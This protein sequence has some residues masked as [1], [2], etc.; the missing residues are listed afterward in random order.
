MSYEIGKRYLI[1]TDNWFRAPDGECYNAAFGTLRGIYSSEEA[2]GVRTNAKSTNWYVQ[3]GNLTI[4]GCQIH[5][6][7]Q[8]DGVS[9]APP[10][11]EF[12]HADKHITARAGMTRIYDADPR[13]DGPTVLELLEIRGE[14]A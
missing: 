1:T 7:I 12:D 13:D 4:A 3:L 2:L 14:A 6:V 11:V 8:T 9:F 5:Y 10:A